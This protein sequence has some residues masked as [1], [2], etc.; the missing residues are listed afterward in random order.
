[1]GVREVGI[2]EVEGEG[3]IGGNREEVLMSVGRSLGEK[4]RGRRIVERVGEMMGR[5]GKVV[6]G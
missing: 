4:S 3:G 2:R 1:M 6:E 5:L